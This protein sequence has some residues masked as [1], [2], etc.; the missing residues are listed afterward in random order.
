VRVHAAEA[1]GHFS[2]PRLVPYLGALLAA[3][4]D[5]LVKSAVRSLAALGFVEAQPFLV[6]LLHDPRPGV[7]REAVRALGVLGA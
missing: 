7:R 4:D 2:D 3:E 5:A 1:L 6:P